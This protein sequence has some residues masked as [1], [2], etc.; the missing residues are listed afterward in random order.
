MPSGGWARVKAD[1]TKR[2]AVKEAMRDAF[3][4]YEEYAMVGPLELIYFIHGAHV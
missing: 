1:V 4:K 2:E 3:G